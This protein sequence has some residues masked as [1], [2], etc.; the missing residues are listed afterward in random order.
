[1]SLR[2]NDH[3]PPIGTFAQLAG[4]NLRLSSCEG[5]FIS[6]LCRTSHAQKYLLPEIGLDPKQAHLKTR[7]NKFF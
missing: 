4:E 3:H 6:I 5:M 1:M 2:S 7:R